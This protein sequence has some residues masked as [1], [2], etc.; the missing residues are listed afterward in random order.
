M[1]LDIGPKVDGTLPEEEVSVLL[2]IGEWLKMNG[3]AIYGTRP[4]KIIGEGPT[5]NVGGA[6]FSENKYKDYTAQ[7]I[8]LQQRPTPY[9]RSFWAGL[10]AQPPSI[11]SRK[12]SLCDS[13]VFSA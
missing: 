3:E 12:T 5:R 6:S 11:P 1:M 2:Q 9:M 4:W 7:D 13:G 10:A 8:R